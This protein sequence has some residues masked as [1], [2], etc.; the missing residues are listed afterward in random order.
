MD[1]TRSTG[2]TKNGRRE[3]LNMNTAYIDASQVYGSSD[4]RARILRDG[5]LLKYKY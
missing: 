3:Q 2:C 1:F 4:T 5:G